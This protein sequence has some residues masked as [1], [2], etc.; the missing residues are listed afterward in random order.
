MS[1]RSYPAGSGMADVPKAQAPTVSVDPE[2]VMR[3]G[4]RAQR[5][6]LAR[7]LKRQEAQAAAKSGRH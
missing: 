1:Y 5:R 4:S 3:Y 6:R 2:W 7:V